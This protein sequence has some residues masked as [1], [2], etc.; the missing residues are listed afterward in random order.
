[1]EHSGFA[2]LL[3]FDHATLTQIIVDCARRMTS[4][5]IRRL[6]LLSAHGG[7]VQALA[8]AA[9][10]LA[11]ELPQL[12]VWTPGDMTAIGAAMLTEAQ[13]DGIAPETAGLHAGEAETSEML[14]LQPQL[15]RMEQATPGYTGDMDAVMP[16]L[17]GAG[18]LPVAPNGV[19]GDPRLARAERGERYLAAQVRSC[20]QQIAEQDDQAQLATSANERT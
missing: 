14:H 6:I 18:L 5:G 12:Q 13:T 17:Q 3:S 19:L 10:Q 15:V 11:R 4:W 2:G 9:E 16:H 8:M 20:E 7:N 1:D